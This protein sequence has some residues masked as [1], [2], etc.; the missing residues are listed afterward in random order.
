MERHHRHFLT[1]ADRDGAHDWLTLGAADFADLFQLAV[2]PEAEAVIAAKDLAYRVLTQAERDAHILKILRILDEPAVVSGPSRLPAWEKGW[3]ANLEEYR[4]SNFDES[5]LLPHYYRR[6]ATIMRLRGDYVLPRGPLFEANFLAALQVIIAKAYFA[7]TPAIQEFGCGPGHNLLAFSRIA[8]GKLYHG[9]DWAAPSAEIL[10]LA[11]RHA[12]KLDP[13]SRF[14]G[15]FFDLFAPDPA[16][17]LVPGGAAFTFGALEQVGARF[18]PFYRWLAGQPVGLVV[19]IEP[20]SEFRDPDI[21]FDVLADR[22][23][24]RR[25]YLE[26]YLDFLRARRAAGE[27]DILQERKLLGS[28]FY[29]GWCLVAWRPRA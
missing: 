6:G 22:Y 3:G 26:G 9:F 20:F 18:E 5:A 23:A 29:D 15:D 8:P 19:H 24:K 11:D 10:R 2:P 17:R 12:A 21:L 27:I 28:A 25:N 14:R 4:A 1:E 13:E 7:D 16:I